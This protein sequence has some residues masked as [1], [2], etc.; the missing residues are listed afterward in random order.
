M[1]IRFVGASDDHVT[2]SCTHFSYDRKEVQFLVDCGLHQGEN[3]ALLKNRQKFPFD[4]ADIKFVL[5]THAHLDHCGLIPKL[6]RDGFQGVVFCTTATAQ[7]ARLSLLDSVRFSSGLYSE[8]DV[9]AIQFSCVDQRP[10]FGLSRYL[11][12]D[13]DLFVSF[14]RTA[15]ILGAMSLK[16]SWNRDDGTRGDIVMSGDLGNNT[17][18]NPFQPLLA[19]RQ[20]PFGVPEYMVVES[21]YGSRDRSPH[22]SNYLARLDALT[23]V[24]KDA[25]LNR[26]K[27]L[28]P[29]FSLQ[30]TQEILLDLVCILESP[31][32]RLPAN[33]P[34]LPV[35]SIADYIAA[36]SWDEA[37]NGRIKRA[38]EGQSEELQE[39]WRD[40]IEAREPNESDAP[41]YGFVDNAQVN[42]ADFRSLMMGYTKPLALKIDVDSPL[43]LK[44][45]SVFG[46]E[47]CRRQKRTP[48]ETLYRNRLMAE[49]LRLSSEAEV[50]DKIRTIFPINKELTGIEIPLGAHV[51]RYQ[52]LTS[53]KK[54][55]HKGK[56]TVIRPKVPPPAHITISGGGMCEGGRVVDHLE[57]LL[58]SNQAVILITGYMASGTLGGKLAELGK[59]RT[60]GALPDFTE[61]QVNDT[62][63]RLDDI[64]AQIIDVGGY[65]SGHADQSGLLQYIFTD[66]KLLPEEG[67]K[68]T[69]VFLNHGTKQ[70]R[71]TLKEAIE[72]HVPGAMERKVA[73]VEFADSSRW[74]SLDLHNWIDPPPPEPAFT[75]TGW[76]VLLAEQKRTNALLERLIDLMLLRQ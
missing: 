19:G 39:Q 47:L 59:C 60:E 40:A 16:I 71:A 72:V 37:T 62:V 54:S 12:V 76:D 63:F 18:G 24:I 52:G 64:R 3:H 1:R 11:P 46:A 8:D 22:F 30:R 20:E 41:R 34:I 14:T 61:I 70:S 73:K 33:I 6:Y 38:L 32:G 57:Q 27:I 2:G 48:D 15:H 28:I 51:L 58:P 25:A 42:F 4:A 10:D 65:Y 69:T 68:A 26:G 56:K 35:F 53:A 36:G 66:H 44:M 7:L 43:T 9:K 5:L 50:D 55:D 21:T 29:A 31:N 75:D 45:T 17:K 23:D 67:D 74:Y 49:R 13:D